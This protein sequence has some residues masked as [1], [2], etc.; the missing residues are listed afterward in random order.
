MITHAVV[1]VVRR[2]LLV[3]IL[4]RY[5]GIVSIFGNKHDDVYKQ[6]KHLN[7]PA[8][9]SIK[10]PDG[11]IIDCVHISHQLAFDHPLLKNH[12]IQM[13]PSYHPESDEGISKSITQLWHLNGRCP[14]GT[15]P[16]RRTKKKEILRASSIK[17]FG[18]KQ[19]GTIPEP[20]MPTKPEP[21]GPH[22]HA[23]VV[24]QG[25]K[26]YGTKATMNVW[27]P[28]VQQSNEFSLSQ[29]W[30]M[31]GSYPSDLSTVEAGWQV[32]PYFYG[33]DNPRLFIYWTRDAYQKTGC[34]NLLCAGF[35]QTNNNVT[36]GGAIFPISAYNAAQYEY[37][38]FVWKQRLSGSSLNLHGSKYKVELGQKNLNEEDLGQN[39][40]N[41]GL[42]GPID[43][44]EAVFSENACPGE[45][46][47]NSDDEIS[48]SE[49]E[50]VVAQPV[51]ASC[52]KNVKTQGK[53]ISRPRSEKEMAVNVGPQGRLWKNRGKPGAQLRN[54][55][56]CCDQEYMPGY[57]RSLSESSM[58]KPGLNLEVVLGRIKGSTDQVI[59]TGEHGVDPSVPAQPPENGRDKG[60]KVA[61]CGQV[62]GTKI[63]GQ[64]QRKM[65]KLRSTHQF[66]QGFHRG[67]IF[68]AAAA[69]MSSSLSISSGAYK[70]ILSRNE[71]QETVKMGK[72]LGIDF[73]VNEESVIHKVSEMD[74]QDEERLTK[75][76]VNGVRW[77]E[78]CMSVKQGGLGIKNISL[79]NDS[80]LL[81]WWWRYGQED[82]ALWK[83]VICE[84][85]GSD[86]GRWFPDKEVQGPI[87]QI[88]KDIL[89]VAQRNGSIIQFYKD[90]VEI[91]IG[92]GQRISFWRDNWLGSTNLL[93]QFPRLFQLVNDKEISL[94]VQVAR[95]V[96]QSGW[97]FNFN[98]PLR[99]WEEGE[100]VRLTTALGSGPLLRSDVADSL[101]WKAAQPG[102][103]KV[104]AVYAWAW[105]GRLKTKDLLHRVGILE[106][107]EV[108]NCIF[109]HED[110]TRGAWWL[111]FGNEVVGYW[112]TSLFSYLA[113]SASQI[114]WGG[115]VMN[116]A[117]DGQHTTTQMGSGHFPEEGFGKA[118]Y[119]KN[120]Q[121]VDGSSNLSAP[122]G[123]STRA[124]Q[125]NCYNVQTGKSS[126]WGN[127]I[128]Y[129]GPGRN[130]NCSIIPTILP[131][132]PRL[133]DFYILQ[134][135]L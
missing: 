76:G 134:C 4:L 34:Y 71:A 92:N 100:L 15:I 19:H 54:S 116:L 62:S 26:Y 57:M 36:L 118:S 16:I 10:S 64:S 28:T 68:R 33:D 113:D 2:W 90:N 12:T 131:I 39:N 74:R 20:T 69:V 112:P 32:F 9:K 99:A 122:I 75:K 35:I 107:E 117:S 91:L 83:M 17:S 106:G 51:V 37:D 43:S 11:D 23:T 123:V 130:P 60:K 29:L 52:A 27:K 59:H 104:N 53:G 56:Q 31:A 94:N 22:E 66:C 89:S 45:E 47:G 127:Y 30:I 8:L 114:Q 78:V 1:V 85:Y 67:A 44:G 96:S 132:P 129:G 65:R 46:V 88:W 49:D 135:M 98:R 97:A 55:P 125:S 14:E 40:L 50:G 86:G 38:F 102:T 21:I 24:V 7:K 87:S 42:Q 95:R 105:R 70:Q 101:G 115:E 25:D 77:K 82:E 128:Y 121:I 80:L 109:C 58:A 84:K 72:V 18:R 5:G 93:S 63:K 120:I 133:L 108:L 126:D 73:G 41:H 6:L 110:T 111:Q 119:I 81:K 13:R 3:L 79:A 61:V 124:E 103:F 48:S